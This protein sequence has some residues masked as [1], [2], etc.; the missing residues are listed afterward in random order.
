MLALDG[1][2]TVVALLPGRFRWIT[3]AAEGPMRLA[4]GCIA[5]MEGDV[6]LRPD[7]DLEEGFLLAL[8][9]GRVLVY[10]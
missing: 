2:G 7:P 8:G 6:E 3:C 10:G 5:A 9:E 4:S 1:Q